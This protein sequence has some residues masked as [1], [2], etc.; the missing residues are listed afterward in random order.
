MT[1]EYLDLSS[2]HLGELAEKLAPEYERAE[3]FPHVV[4]DD[5]L[6]IECLA[7]IVRQF[8]PV[9]HSSW[10]GYENRR[11]SLKLGIED[12]TVIP[13]PHRT[14]LRELNSHMFVDFLENLTGLSGLIPDPRS[15]GGGL[16][17]M[18][19]GGFML[20]TATST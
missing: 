9:D 8:P 18:L 19:P 15:R 12:E 4:I 17:Q 6:P 16:H 13:A 11:E 7:P 1:G 5:F 2:L 10:H 20:V 14:L 3:P